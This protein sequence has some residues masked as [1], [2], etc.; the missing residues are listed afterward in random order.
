MTGSSDNWETGVSFSTDRSDLTAGAHLFHFTTYVNGTEVRFPES[1]DL[2]FNVTQSV[3]GWDLAI[4]ALDIDYVIVGNEVQLS[5]NVSNEGIYAYEDVPLIAQLINPEGEILD[6]DEVTI[7]K[8]E[9]EESQ[10]FNLDVTLPTNPPDGLYQIPVSVLPEIDEDPSNNTRT[11]SI[12]F[13]ESLESDQY[14]VADGIQNLMQESTFTVNGHT[15]LVS[16]VGKEEVMLVVEGDSETLESKQLE[17][18]DAWDIAIAIDAI[19]SPYIDLVA[20]IETQSGP[21]FAQTTI[22]AVPGETIVFEATAPSGRTF[23]KEPDDDEIYSKNTTSLVVADWSFN[24]DTFDDDTRA[25]FQFTIPSDATNGTYEFYLLTY[26][27][28]SI[29]AYLTKLAIIVVDPTPQITTLSKST[30]SA[31]DV[32]TITGSNLGTSGTVRFGSI[33][34]SEIISWS[35]T[36]VQCVVPE[37][38]SNGNI[39][40]ITNAGTSNSLAYQIISSTGDPEIALPIPDQSISSGA[41]KTIADLNTVFTDPNGDALSYSIEISNA[42]LS[43]DADA[44]PSGTLVLSAT[45]DAEGT[46]EVSVTATDADN[47]SIT[48]IF[49]VDIDSAPPPSQA[50]SISGTVTDEG[51]SGLGGVLFTLSGDASATTSTDASGGYTFADLAD[52]AYTVTPSLA[53]YSFDPTSRNVTIAGSDVAG[54]D[55]SASATGADGL[56]AYYPFNGNAN[57]ESGNGHDGT[58]FGAT[59][60]LDRFG[61]P[62][63]AYN[64]NGNDSRID[65]GNPVDFESPL[66]FSGWFRLDAAAESQWNTL[67]MKSQYCSGFGVMYNADT[68][69]SGRK[70]FRI[71]NN[72]CGGVTGADVDYMVTYEDWVHYTLVYDGVSLETYI[73]GNLVGTYAYSSSIFDEDQMWLGANGPDDRVNGYYHFTGDIDDVRIY[74]R[75]LTSEEVLAL[76]EEG[77]WT[78]GSS[79]SDGLVAYYPFSGDANDASGNGHD[80]V[81]NGATLTSDRFGSDNAA[82]SFD[83]V[84]D[85]IEVPSDSGFTMSEISISAWIWMDRDIGNEQARIVNR[86]NT[87]G[88]L[89]AWGLEIF[90]EDYAG[91]GP[92][93]Q[94]VLHANTGSEAA[95]TVSTTSL[96]AGQWYHVVGT[97]DGQEIHLYINGV[98]DTTAPAPGPLDQSNSADVVMGKTGTGPQHYFPGI[99]DDLRIYNRALSETEVVALCQEGGWQ[100][101]GDTGISLHSLSGTITDEGGNGLEGV[102]L[103]LSGDASATTSTDASGDYA[104]TDLADGAYTVTPSLAGYTFDPTSRDVTIAGSDVAGQDFSA[105]TTG[106]PWTASPTNTSGV[107]LGQATIDGVPAAAEDCIAAFDEDGNVAG[108]VNLIEDSGNAFISL[109]I[110]GDDLSTTDIDEGINTGESFT[111]KLYDASAAA[112]VYL[113][114]AEVF[115]EWQNTN[116]APMPAYDDPNVI[117]NFTSEIATQVLALAEGWNLFSLYVQPVDTDLPIIFDPILNALIYVTG[118]DPEAGAQFYDPDGLDFLNTL[119]NIEAG[120]GYWVKV[121]QDTSLSITGPPLPSDH[122]IDL[123]EGWNLIGYW[124]EAS[125]SPEDAFAELI[126]AGT[127]IYV[128]GFDPEEGA[129]FYDPD[130]LPFLNTL[131]LLERGRGYWVKVTED[132][133]GFQYPPAVTQPALTVHRGNAS[134]GL[135]NTLENA[136]RD[137]TSVGKTAASRPTPVLDVKPTNAFMFVQGTVQFENTG[138]VP[139]DYVEVLNRQGQ[140]VGAMQILNNGYLLT[141][142]VYGDDATTPELDGAVAGETLS[143][144]YAG[145]E[146]QP[147]LQFTADMSVQQVSLNFAAQAEEIPDTFALEANYPNPFNPVTTIRY[148]L[149]QS[150]NVRLEVYNTL[151]QRVAVL[152]DEEREAGWHEITFHGG[153][154]ASGVYLY[155]LKAADFEQIRPM[156]LLK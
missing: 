86:Q 25:D 114:S 15:Y 105:S 119:K 52:G 155:R 64:F 50:Y 99:I 7:I 24:S 12:Y 80:G 150:A 89:E 145:I 23:G 44:L 115:T 4:N 96:D 102:T 18:W 154:L 134:P 130:G 47:A 87:S 3:E 54:Q 107:F 71:Y 100:T 133:G 104:F 76:C 34:A 143:F 146:L 113:E 36:S 8:I 137:E 75:A 120:R 94:L 125:A 118:F 20:G 97:S 6:E 42:A 57:D 152:V 69:Q 123:R 63:S 106:C 68:D 58:V 30:F 140:I 74:D 92:G 156:L 48:D 122:A 93:N 10:S 56:V 38:V 33:D 129:Q 117:Y 90:G 124:I 2:S 111:L 29:E 78:C 46:A 5:L 112:T 84:N 67:F 61:T 98:L 116:G 35:N 73:N 139:G 32:L 19:I 132:V 31:D 1:G 108:V 103:T 14:E 72:S 149:P 39:F 127:L 77:G 88:G 141:T 109:V 142:P 51:G 101:C 153:N 66:S 40:I 110:Y 81:V 59:L 95:N 128:T 53:G 151:G 148:G 26:H 17:T 131:D 121:E 41:T 55:F 13:G 43:Y 27:D 62:N 70:F 138:H 82:Y 79:A 144:R 9:P 21:T 45:T 136:L 16:V 135:R 147:G 60:T 28:G 85:Y 22:T 65:L 83:G 126:D 11:I 37:G 91:S 49:E